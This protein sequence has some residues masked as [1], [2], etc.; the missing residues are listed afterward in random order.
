L[1]AYR[2]GL[3]SAGKPPQK[4]YALLSDALARLRFDA[5]CQE[6]RSIPVP[7]AGTQPPL[8]VHV[9]GVRGATHDL[10]ADALA[11]LAV[12][13]AVP[14]AIPS[15][16]VLQELFNMTPAEARVARAAAQ[17]QT[18]Q[19][20]ATGLGLSPGRTSSSGIA[21][22]VCNI[23]AVMLAGACSPDSDEK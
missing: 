16:A 15:A 19:G 7:A 8:L 10:F 21:R 22:R 12:A 5:G 4:A 20:I 2:F 17:R 3:G 6:V 18:I 13:P 9:I 14:K 1:N 23:V 11:I